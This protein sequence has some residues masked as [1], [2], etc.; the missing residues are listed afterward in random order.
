[1]PNRGKIFF[2][3]E[4]VVSCCIPGDG[5]MRRECPYSTKPWEVLVNQNF[6]LAPLFG[7]DHSGPR[8]S[9]R[10]WVWISQYTFLCYLTPIAPVNLKICL[11]SWWLLNFCCGKSGEELPHPVNWLQSGSRFVL[12]EVRASLRSISLLCGK[13]PPKQIN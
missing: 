7:N 1:M 11:H 10:P 13:H 2:Y 6:P 3:T 12:N 8:I 4:K 9:R 5:L